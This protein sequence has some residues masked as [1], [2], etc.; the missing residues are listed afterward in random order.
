MFSINDLGMTYGARTLFSGASINFGRGNRYG[1]VGANGS[2][3]STLL[4]IM[5]GL[6]EPTSGSVSIP[7][8][9]RVGLLKQ[10]HFAYEAVPIIHVV[11]MGQPVLWE[12]MHEKE[13]MLAAAESDPEA[14]DV[15]RFGELEDIVMK[16]D[17]YAFEAKAAE[18]LE[19][20]N[21][22]AE[23][24][25]EP[26]RVLSGGYKLRVL[27]AQ[28]L[29]S[30]PDIL[31]LDEPTNHLDIVSIAWLERFLVGFDGCVVV[32]SHDQQFLNT[33]C[34]HILDVDYEV[35]TLYKGNYDQF[36][37]AKVEDRDRKESEI[38]KQEAKIEEHKKFIQRF[39]AKAT[40]ARQAQSRVKQMERIDIEILPQSSRQHPL[41]KLGAERQTGATVVEVEHVS[42]IYGDKVVLDDVSLTVRRGERVAI[43]GPNGIGKS[44]LL[45][46]M[47]GEV[48]PDEGHSEWGHAV[49]PGYYAQEPTHMKVAA[50][51]QL[52]DWLWDYAPTESTGFIRGK[53]AEVLFSQDDVENNVG[54][55]SG[56][57]K[58]RLDFARLG[59]QQPTTLVLDEPTNHLDL[60]GIEALA[61]G[62]KKY[63]NAIIFVSHDRW[64][65]SQLATR[66][67]EITRDGIEDFRG[68]YAEFLR[69]AAAEDHL[70][71]GRAAGRR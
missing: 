62:L 26:L 12:A 58:A 18:I 19:G 55:L 33:I 34:T 65:V 32:V 11:M 14:F 25:Y 49:V 68:T 21:I 8:S 24:H 64:F 54:N 38:E 44:T 4:R 35:V 53:L 3:K 57:E 47:M 70:E 37:K 23:Q 30:N 10:D 9:A 46:I 36:E 69:K 63:P 27:L 20:L 39:K 61:E 31:F 45:K 67:I 48:E 60:E 7:N 66:I 71:R 15:D 29:A 17:G 2:G 51:M 43:I 41:F 59:V 16:F 28:T 40:K 56:G 6:E 52:V 13:E 50:D 1:I 42:K 22:P 5:S